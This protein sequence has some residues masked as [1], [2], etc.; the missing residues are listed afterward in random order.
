MAGVAA[1]TAKSV[2]IPRIDQAPTSKDRNG[3][4]RIWLDRNL[5][6]RLLVHRRSGAK[7]IVI[8][9]CGSLGSRRR[10]LKSRLAMACTPSRTFARLPCRLFARPVIG[11]GAA[12]WESSWRSTATLW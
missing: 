7:A 11:A 9:S 3:R 2:R 1:A 5:I 4:M 8:S 10:T 12:T 6:D